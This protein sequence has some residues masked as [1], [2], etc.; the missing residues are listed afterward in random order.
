MS[1]C[2]PPSSSSFCPPNMSIFFGMTRD[3][4]LAAIVTLQQA[5]LDLMTGNKGESFTYSQGD[6]TKSVVYTRAQIANLTMTIAQL[7]AEVYGGRAR[8]PLRFNF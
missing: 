8:R 6:G 4:K 5:Y 7:Q 1:Y 3:A 2:P